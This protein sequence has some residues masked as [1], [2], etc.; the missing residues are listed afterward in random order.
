MSDE[1]VEG[2]S[3]LITGPVNASATRDFIFETLIDATINTSTASTYV[4]VGGFR[5]FSLMARF[6]GTASAKIR[7]E[8]MQN[9]LTLGRE[10]FNIQA[11]GWYNFSK[12]YDVFAPNIHVA[13]YEF[14]PNLKVRMYLYAGY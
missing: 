12:V 6:E 4:N 7:F 2:K 13:I 11:G 8:I 5:K 3:E 14:P 9:N 1:I 10:I